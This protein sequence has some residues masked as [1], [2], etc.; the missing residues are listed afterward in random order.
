V[1]KDDEISKKKRKRNKEI[2]SRILVMNVNDRFLLT[3]I[4][5]RI[6]GRRYLQTNVCVVGKLYRRPLYQ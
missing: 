5:Q 6:F 1:Q 3:G 4:Y 2:K